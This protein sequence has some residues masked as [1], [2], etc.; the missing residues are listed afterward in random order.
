MKIDDFLKASGAVV[1]GLLFAAGLTFP[2]IVVGILLG[3]FWIQE[4]LDEKNE[5]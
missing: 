1:I 3:W 5:S 2:L 4:S